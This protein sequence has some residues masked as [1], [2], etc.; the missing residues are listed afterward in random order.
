MRRAFTVMALVATLMSGCAAS[1]SKYSEYANTATPP[2]PSS[3]R[4][5][6]FRTEDSAQYSTRSVSVKID[7][8]SVSSCA[9]SGFNTFD[10]SANRHTLTVDM[11]DAPGTC[12]LPIDVSKGGEFFFEIS[13]RT[14]SL[15]SGLMFGAIGMAA[16]SSGKQC[17]G[18]FAVAPVA[19]N[20]AAKKLSTLRKTE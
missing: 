5:V 2:T 11:W 1:G 15:V 8:T 14:Q 9:P 19:R 6:V 13:P 7:G 3:A 17:G 16:E 12:T 4:L 20:I 10:V 18:A